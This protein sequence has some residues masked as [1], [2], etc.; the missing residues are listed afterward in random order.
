M[1][2]VIK[3]LAL[4][5]TFLATTWEEMLE[6]S[7]EDPSAWVVTR[8]QAREPGLKKGDVEKEEQAEQKEGQKEEGEVCCRRRE[9]RRRARDKTE[10]KPGQLVVSIPMGVVHQ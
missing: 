7:P 10:N 8:K 4:K 5:A 2:T 6:A 1:G 3:E 9:N